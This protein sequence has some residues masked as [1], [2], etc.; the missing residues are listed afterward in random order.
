MGGTIAGDLRVDF[1]R[2]HFESVRSDRL[3]HQ[4]SDCHAERFREM[5]CT[6]VEESIL[7]ADWLTARQC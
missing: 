5:L 3:R 6:A 7:T 1:T 4:L 2:L